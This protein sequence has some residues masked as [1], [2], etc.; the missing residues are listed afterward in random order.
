MIPDDVRYALDIM[1]KHYDGTWG[2]W[3]SAELHIGQM[4][5][6]LDTLP[7]LPEPDWTQAPEWAMWWAMDA[8]GEPFWMEDEPAHFDGVWA[9]DG[10]D[11]Y[12][13]SISSQKMVLG[14]DWRLTLAARPASEE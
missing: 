6:W 11:M 13:P 7:Q 4:R 3:P 5:N 2:S 8:D 1:L 12:D 9:C 14:I 10:R